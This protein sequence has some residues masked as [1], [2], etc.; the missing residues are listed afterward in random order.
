M[1]HKTI[2]KCGVRR[3][4]T[5]LFIEECNFFMSNTTG[6][7]FL[8]KT[9]GHIS[10]NC[11]SENIVY[12]IFCKKCNFQYIGETKNRIQTRFSGHK[13]SIKSGTSCQLIHK[14]FEENGHG[15]VNC[16]IIPIEK[17][18]ISLINQQNLTADQV[19]NT[20][21]KLRLER[22]KFW[23]TTLQTAYPFGLN[24]R[25]KGIGDFNPSQGSY[26][27]FGGRRRRRN[28]RHSRRKPKRLR[29]KSDISLSFINKKHQ[30]LM[31]E[32]GYIH[33][34]KTFLY[35]L[36]RLQLLTLFNDIQNQQTNINVRVKDLIVMI[37]NLR[38]FKPTQ[39]SKV[40]DSKR[41]FFHIN[42]RDKGL[43]HINIS[44]ILRTKTVI[45][46][47]PVYF[48]DKEPPIVG[49]KFNKSIGGKFFNYKQF[50]TEDLDS[51]DTDNITCDCHGSE[52]KDIIHNHIITGNFNII[53]NSTLRE[54]FKKG[55]K[56]R[57][58]QRINWQEDK[59]II[60]SFL[61][62]Y[63]DKWVKKE[64]KSDNTLSLD[65]NSLYCWK[66]EILNIVDRRIISGT[67]IFGKTS[68]I[69]LEGS[70]REELERL[71]NKFVLT[72]TDKAQNNILFT[73][74]FYY[75]KVLREELT[76]PG[77]STY[78]LSNLSQDLINN[79]I[80]AFSESKNI[81]IKEEM[82]E[83]P[84]IYWIPKMHKNPVGSRFIAGSRICSIKSL[85]K[86]FSKALKLILNHMKLY[87]KTVYERSGLN[88]YW[89]LD[90]SLEFLES[91]REQ[92]IDY[93]ETYDFSTLYT[94][95]P[96]GEIK[97][98]FSRL[99]QKVYDREAK[100]FINISYKKT[101][102]S[103]S[104]NKNGCSLTILDMKE[105][106]SFI[107]DN[108][109]VKCGKNIYK[110]VIGIPIGLDSGQ[111]IANLLLFCYESEYV[112]KLSKE[113]IVLARKFNFNRRYIDDLFVANFPEF[114]NHIYKIY[115]RELEI[116]LES[117]NPKNLSYLD[118][119]I[120]SNND[121]LTFSVYDKR[122]DF[123]FEIVNYPFSD[124]CIP[125]K[126]ALGVYV[127]QLLRYARICSF[128]Q[129][130]K[131]KSHTLVIKLRNQGYK[132]ADL[133][134]LTLKFFQERKDILSKY[135]IANANIFLNDIV[136]P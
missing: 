95:L 12:M 67:K 41:E 117:S 16:R 131:A 38:L 49:Y 96:H 36:P 45:D 102:F 125:K 18:D 32:Q 127:S 14:H 73:C 55:P 116:K 5:C 54:M 90:N 46:K 59:K 98:K 85:S 97:R 113:D 58:P 128:F 132:E 25:V 29:S 89:I 1:N 3:C 70:L 60:D 33:Y 120:V 2:Q 50:L 130:F 30:E 42:F 107:L 37:T 13:S 111:D 99:F 135:N 40:N 35:G 101:Y 69:K 105:I 72:P 110:Q 115:P 19:K 121:D 48:S 43:D 77:Q 27:D 15:L 93:M 26:N 51:I 52:Y 44:G 74:K 65:K 112:E 92:K 21:N 78:I 34:F 81:K 84:L 39:I 23:I 124:S 66:K 106:L 126:S 24:S 20:L 136:H 76:K 129:D 56:Y 8:P 62:D 108:I 91:L 82:K 79:D 94:A 133:R 71:Q 63:I 109:F 22:E 88:Y 28:K 64:K 114:K 53:E 4:C 87:N 57:L 10:L 17:I 119:K 100:K 123:N 11:K 86:V 31:N 80:I 103:N 6:V 9:N 68:S 47:I 61:N 7:R 104:E 75:L 134:R 122:D 118:L 83:I